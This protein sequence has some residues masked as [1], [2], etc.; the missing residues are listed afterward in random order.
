MPEALL[1]PL[2]ALWADALKLRYDPS[3]A[4]LDAEGTTIER[5]FPEEAR[6]AD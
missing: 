2:D 6:E 1:H 4:A 3:F 5:L